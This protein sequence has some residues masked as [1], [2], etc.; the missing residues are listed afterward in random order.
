MVAKTINPAIIK[1]CYCGMLFIYQ[2]SNFGKVFTV[3]LSMRNN[4]E[5]IRNDEIE[6]YV[7]VDDAVDIFVL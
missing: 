4:A 6:Q 7:L 5:I 3:I 1:P 2:N